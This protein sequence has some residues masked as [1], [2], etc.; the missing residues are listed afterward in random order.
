MENNSHYD[1][2]CK[3]CEP[4]ECVH[5]S[6]YT[7]DL[8]MEPYDG[9]FQRLLNENL[10]HYV[11]IDFLV[12]SCEL[13]TLSGIIESVT[14]RYVSLHNTKNHC[15][16]IGDAWAIKTVTFPCCEQTTSIEKGL[17]R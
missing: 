10:G 11:S 5:Y 1:P 17:L 2:C 12:S 15:R 3:P 9:S 4:H 8:S 14:G 6:T 7:T 13:R 16:V